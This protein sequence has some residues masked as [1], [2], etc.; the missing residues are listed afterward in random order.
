MRYAKVVHIVT[1]LDFGGVETHMLVLSNSL[2]QARYEH[3]F[4]AIAT[5]GR[6]FDEIA[7]TDAPARYLGASGRIPSLITFLRLLRHLVKERPAIVHTHGAEANFHGLAAAWLAGVP[8]R[9]GE[10]IGIPAHGRL[11]RLGFRFS[12]LFSHSVI[13]ISDAVRHWL[14]NSREVP[15]D[16]AIRLYNPVRLPSAR[17][18]A[19]I[20]RD[21]F[22]IG[23]VGRLEEVKNPLGLLEAFARLTT[24][25]TPAQLWFIGDGSQ[26]EM[27][28]QRAREL[29]VDDHV[30]FHGFQHD[31]AAFIRQCSVYAQPSLSEGFGLA[32]VEAMG[33]E[34]PVIATAV[35]GLP[36]ILEHGKTGWLLES[37][38]VQ[39][40]ADALAALGKAARQSVH[41]R[42]SPL[43]YVRQLETIYS[44]R[45]R[46]RP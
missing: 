33:C 32:V 21:V 8:V 20:P 7:R 26:R 40:L 29:R 43:S 38:D 14:V 35:G 42:F 34:V 2:Q 18:P 27:L 22:R 6:V 23:F 19:D 3:A 17:S 25:G 28:M 1:S 10:E 39:L 30:F 24:S 5:G 13:G 16:K 12:Y 45:L 44:E 15:A 9:I 4:C 11:A 37:A 41:E 36:E 31:P 46:R